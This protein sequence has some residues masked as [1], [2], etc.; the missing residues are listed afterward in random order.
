MPAPKEIAA[1]LA[2]CLC[3]GATV[4]CAEGAPDA[5]VRPPAVA[6]Q[7]YPDG[8][9]ALE[10]AVRGYLADALPP[11][12][13][14]PVALVAPHAGYVFSG[15]IAA[16][17][18]RQAADFAYDV[19]VVLGTNHTT[20]GFEQVSVY[21]GAGYRTPLGVAR[22]DQEL[23]GKLLENGRTVT[24]RPEVHAREHSVE[25]QVPFVQAAF[26]QARLV[27][28]VVGSPDPALTERFGRAL[29]AALE[30]RRA[31]IVASS[32]LSH[33]PD[34]D[35]AAAVDGKVLRAIASLD[36]VAVSSVIT[37]QMRAGLPG[38]GTCA[39]GEGPVLAAMV[40]A[41]ALGARRGI[42]VSYANSGD[43]VFGRPSRVVGYG[44]VAFT[45]GAGGPDMGANT[46]SALAP[47]ASAAGAAELADADREY[48]LGLA[49]QT[50]ERYLRTGTVPLPRP[51]SPAL[52]RRQGA[53]VT[54]EEEGRLRGCIGHMVEDTPLALTVAR[55][56]LQAAF[57]D[58]RF[59][60]V[61]AEELPAL[62]VEISALTPF[63]RVPG[64]EAIAIGRDGVVLEKEGHRAVYLPHV[65]PEQ[66][67]GREEMLD[68]LC[69]KAG[70][71]AGC[72]RHDADLFTFQAEVFGER[73]EP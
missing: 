58:P 25:V 8:A 49:R 26:P 34:R 11:C 37:R 46:P 9:E 28:A 50:V 3:C 44:A 73:E 19:V 62:A 52:R 27:A 1:F 7:F 18:Y 33:Y 60:P 47:P 14:R 45:A 42:V 31:L 54:F 40:A 23:A 51:S 29:A 20:A 10:E 64:P 67:W 59:P 69:Q 22:I 6:G 39:C 12:G 56:A 35:D 38:L 15:Q 43:T 68:Q 16:D 65:A 53:F 24:F 36:P 57:R 30:G 21:Q 13:E 55:M 48:L 17:A 66:G 70:L 71:S 4:A 41:Q 63:T 5:G 61:R 72:W 32:D 2:V